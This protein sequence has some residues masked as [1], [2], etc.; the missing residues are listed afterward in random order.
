MFITCPGNLKEVRAI[1]DSSRKAPGMQ[2]MMIKKRRGTDRA[3]DR[4]SP[5]GS[6]S[7]PGPSGRCGAQGPPNATNLKEPYLG[8]L[9][10]SLRV[11]VCH[12]R[13]A[14]VSRARYNVTNSRPIVVLS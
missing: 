5:G 7:P 11:P 9:R 4:D 13:L 12:S 3:S 2:P 6:V 14:R 8:Y 1:A 10:D